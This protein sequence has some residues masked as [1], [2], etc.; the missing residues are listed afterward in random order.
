MW[1]GGL[2]LELRRPVVGKLAPAI[3]D[4]RQLQIRALPDSSR[5][6]LPRMVSKR[7][8]RGIAS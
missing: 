5:I 2:Q 4:L 3:T 6:E 1:E 8:I 7:P